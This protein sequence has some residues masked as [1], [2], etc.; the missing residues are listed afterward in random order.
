[1]KAGVRGG[2]NKIKAMIHHDDHQEEAG[3][4]LEKMGNVVKLGVKKERRKKVKER[5]VVA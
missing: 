5:G 4:L 3:H 1:L 2:K